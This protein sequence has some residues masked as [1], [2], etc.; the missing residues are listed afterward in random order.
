MRIV[1]KL[2]IG[3][4]PIGAAAYVAGGGTFGS[5]TALHEW[6]GV[7]EKTPAP[8]VREAAPALSSRERERKAI[9]K[10]KKGLIV[11]LAVGAAA[12]FGGNSTLASFSAETSNRNANV[13]SGTLT[14]SDQVESNSACLTT[15][16]ATQNNFNASCGAPL[17]ISNV[18][19]GVFGGSAKL[20]ILNNG[21]VGARFLYLYASPVNGVLSTQL[22]VGNTVTTL[23]MSTGLEGN[24]SVGDSISVSF[25]THSQT[26]VA[27]AAASGGATSITVTS[28][29]ANYT[30]QAGSSVT[31]TSSD[32]STGP[33]LASTITS[34]TA[35][36]SIP[37]SYLSGNVTAG[38]LITLTTAPPGSVSQTFVATS[39]PSGTASP[40]A[41]SVTSQN[42]TTTFPLTTT[43]VR[44][45]SGNATNAN[46]DCWDAKTTGTAVPPGTVT[47]GSDL[48]FDSTWGNPLCNT[49]LFY[50]QETTNGKNYCWVGKA[51][52][53]Q[54]GAC[55]FPFSTTL[56]SSLSTGGGTISSLPVAALN[57]NVVTGD[58]ITVTSGTNTQTFTASG[59]QYIGDT[60]IAVNPLTPTFAFPSGTTTVTDLQQNTSLS[61]LNSDQTDTIANFDT[62]KGPLGKLELAP[63]SSNGNTLASTYELDAGASR[64]F[65]VGVY[66]PA[67]NGTTQNQ[68]QG[69]ASS[70]GLTWHIDQ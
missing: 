28:Q 58:T 34:G 25:G 51:S 19:P 47:H 13:A 42:A 46:I 23:A 27:T 4:T 63:V 11:L 55:V 26:F 35:V 37:I 68:L 57:G 65:Q 9:L 45:V 40:T 66:F 16:A 56:S 61:L 62:G 53:T 22:T 50:V 20:T 3:I 70:F 49:M 1:K 15:N 52:L 43:T 17:T 54:T 21:S 60:A 8:P 5:F 67:P 39:S 18:A 64:T 29:P 31:D 10:A 69:L 36:T 24:V 32:L 30:Y 44:D 12:F 2:L 14:L 7:P 48:N 38:D 41:I 6:L 33:V 59:N